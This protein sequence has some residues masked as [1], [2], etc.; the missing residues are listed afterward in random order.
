MQRD[1]ADST[2]VLSVAHLKAKTKS[3]ETG[4]VKPILE[5]AGAE[6]SKDVLF[7]TWRLHR[8]FVP[9]HQLPTADLNPFESSSSKES[10]PKYIPTPFNVQMSYEI[11][12]V[13]G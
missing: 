4:R 5:A 2:F 12:K 3:P 11:Q 13:S 7:P 6:A 1:F 8:L 10:S 9:F